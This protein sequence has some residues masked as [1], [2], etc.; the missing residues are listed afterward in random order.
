MLLCALRSWRDLGRER[1]VRRA[2]EKVKA[3]CNF[4]KTVS[5]TGL[6]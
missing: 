3:G 2:A 1:K 4:I 5:G 6:D